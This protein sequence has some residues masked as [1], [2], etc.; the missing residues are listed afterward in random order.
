MVT[1]NKGK[2]MAAVLY[3]DCYKGNKNCPSPSIS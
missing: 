2:Q 1:E 3:S